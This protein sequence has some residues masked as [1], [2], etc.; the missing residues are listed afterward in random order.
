M[1][2]V[3]SRLVSSIR[4]RVFSTQYFEPE[5]VAA[6]RAKGY[7]LGQ[8]KKTVQLSKSAKNFNHFLFGNKSSVYGKWHGLI[9][10]H[11]VGCGVYPRPSVGSFCD[12]D[13]KTTASGEERHGA[14]QQWCLVLTFGSQNAYTSWAAYSKDAI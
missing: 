10:R 9:T 11:E 4:N 5:T 3:A 7:W 14:E 1:R 2:T 13:Y 6:Q 12:S 8:A